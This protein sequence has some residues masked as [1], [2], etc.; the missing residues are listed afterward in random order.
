MKY[1]ENEFTPPLFSI[2]ILSYRNL[3]LVGRLVDSI[4]LQDYPN[5]EI[6]ISD[7]GSA[8]YDEAWLLE[9][10]KEAK[11]RLVRV[12]LLHSHQNQGTVKNLNQALKA[13]EGTYFMTLGADDVLYSSTVV[14]NF[15]ESFYLFGDK[16]LFI[17]SQVANCQN[18][19]KVINFCLNPMDKQLLL[20]RDASSLFNYLC[21]KTVI[22]AVG[23]C[24]KRKL[25]EIV[26]LFDEKYKYYEDIPTYLKA[27]K[28]GVVPFYIDQ[29]STYHPVGGAANGAKLLNS[30]Q[31]KTLYKDQ[32]AI[33]KGD[34]LSAKDLLN[35]FGKKGAQRRLFYYKTRYLDVAFSNAS[36]S[37]KLIY[38]FFN[39][40]WALYRYKNIQKITLAVPTVSLTV[41]CFFKFLHGLDSPLSYFNFF[42]ALGFSAVFLSMAM[43]L[44]KI[45]TLIKIN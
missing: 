43:I 9:L 2:L 30:N 35:S 6:V 36:L 44:L 5:I 42:L 19:L 29:I 34:M 40:T 45:K 1:M 27:I 39:P 26:P 17:C 24:Y 37:R 22:L 12:V 41:Y 28:K 14:S 21:Y 31:L 23:T 33:V 32:L 11:R 18:D 15:V 13:S 7:D 38:I 10:L 3:S 8:D 20:E 25:E 16:A 4:L